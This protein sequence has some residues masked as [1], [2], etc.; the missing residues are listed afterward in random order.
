MDKWHGCTIYQLGSGIAFVLEE[1]VRLTVH[2]SKGQERLHKWT[3]L[4]TNPAGWVASEKNFTS[5]ADSD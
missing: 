1:I 4:F 3:F 2:F 5:L